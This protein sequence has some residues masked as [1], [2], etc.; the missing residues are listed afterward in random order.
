MGF[1]SFTMI[2]LKKAKSITDK[3]K[4]LH[5]LFRNVIIH[6]SCA[7]Q[8]FLSYFDFCTPLRWR[9]TWSSASTKGP[10][11]K[12]PEDLLHNMTSTSTG[13][14]KPKPKSQTGKA[15][16]RSVTAPAEPRDGFWGGRMI[17]THLLL[18]VPPA[19]H[20]SPNPG[21]YTPTLSDKQS[22]SSSR[23]IINVSLWLSILLLFVGLYDK[24]L[25][26][27]LLCFNTFPWTWC[28]CTAGAV[29]P[30]RNLC[31]CTL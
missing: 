18:L 16:K 21:Q 31:I 19:A 28:S 10:S 2:C 25:N 11:W 15:S 8:I 5:N 4:Q 7:K 24:N 30:A 12:L 13:R 20:S 14:P 3:K 6:L 29:P 23:L 27:G 9:L 1:H 22:V 17:V 26:C